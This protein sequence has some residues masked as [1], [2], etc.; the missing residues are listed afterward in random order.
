M[1]FIGLLL[2]LFW[3]CGGSYDGGAVEYAYKSYLHNLFLTEYFW[4]N[5]VPKQVDYA[6]YSSPQMMIDDL[7]YAPKDRWSMVLTKQENNNFF[8]Q[9]SGGFGFAHQANEQGDRVVVYTRIDSPADKAG[10]HRGD[11]LKLIDGEE[12]TLENLQKAILNLDSTTH[13]MVYRASSDETLGID[14]VAQEYSF[15]VTKT[16]MVTSVEGEDVAY[17]R[18]DSFTGS[19]I[20]EIDRAFDY[21]KAQNSQ[22][23]IIDLRY[24]G[25]G[26]VNT[27]SILLDKLMRN[28]DE[29]E[30]FTLKWNE[31]Y[32]HKNE[33]LYF[34]TDEN[35]LNF[36][37]IIFLTSKKSASASELVINALHPY[38]GERLVIIGGQT[39]GKPVGMSGRTEDGEY[40]YYLIN[41]VISNRDGFYDYFDGLEVTEECEV[42]DDLSHE[43]GDEREG[44]LEKALFYIDNNHC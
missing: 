39:Y 12:A 44:L 34:E 36:D 25:G 8:A 4:S 35:S 1:L 22:K 6:Q 38:L 10:L 3:G 28:Q 23:L 2:T 19:A 24:N 31:Q 40:I 32:R 15:K 18:F 41:F 29:K 7:K 9:K 37:R 33:T 43:L 42:E 21:F 17:M 14:I 5:R 30:Q 27:A 16:A 20:A 26:A 13:F 11:V